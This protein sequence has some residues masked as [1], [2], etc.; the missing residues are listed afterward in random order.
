MF[1]PTVYKTSYLFGKKVSVIS[2]NPSYKENN[3]LISEP[4]QKKDKEMT[5]DFFINH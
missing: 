5:S 2:T 1:S 3:G 4:I